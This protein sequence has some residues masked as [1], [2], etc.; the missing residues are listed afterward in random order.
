MAVNN[1]KIGGDKIKKY[2]LEKQE[3]N[4]DCSAAC[5]SMIIQYYKGHIDMETLRDC[6]HIT[7]NGSTAFHL[8]EGARKIGFNANGY[9]CEFADFQKEKIILPCIANVVVN[10]SYSHF[11]VIYE[12]NY[13][14]KELIIADP[15]NKIMKVTFDNF[16]LIYSGVIIILYPEKKLPYTEKTKFSLKN[17]MYLLEGSNKFIINIILLSIFIITYSVIASFYAQFMLRSIENPPNNIKFFFL[18]IIFSLIMIFKIVSEFFR[19]QLFIYITQK[20]ELILGLDTFDKILSLPY[21]YYRNHTTGDIISRIRESSIIRDVISKWLITIII[22]IPLMIISFICIYFISSNLAML[23]LIIFFLYVLLLKIFN[24]SLENAIEHCQEENSNL[25]SNQIESISAFETIKGINIEKFIKFKIEKAQVKFLN[26]LYRFQKITIIETMMKDLIYNIGYFF[27]FLFGC[28]YV[29]NEIISFGSLLTFQSLFGY[30]VNPI[31]Q[32]VDLNTETKN[33]KKA[34]NRLTSIY[35]SDKSKGFVKEEIKGKI[36]FNSLSYSYDN[37]NLILKNINLEISDKEK[38]IIIG[39]SGSGKST[40]FKLLKGYYQVGRNMIYINDIDINDYEK[41]NSILYI[42]QNEIL[43]T[44]S[45]YNN[46]VFDNKIN[47]NEYYEITKLC[48]ID[49]IIKNNNLG[50][51]LLIEEN[52]SNLSGGERQRI[53]LARTLLRNFNILIIDEGLNQLDSDLERR[54]LINLFKK[55]NNKTIIVISHRLEN[56]D[57]FDRMVKFKDGTIIENIV[58]NG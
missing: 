28:L 22:D 37:Y 31:R 19:S 16:N 57:L 53:I 23:S 15:A 56:L 51:S 4:K 36:V 32:L 40:L 41:K 52:G 25:T 35:V 8:I 58:K 20:I 29:Q 49:K 48:E 1:N 21:R 24:N 44:D 46:I 33:A 12:I 10:K 34:F 11:I 38:V 43:F 42:N 3:E 50:Y 45:L 14:K 55:F 18:F 47:Q 2:P 5:I 7:K 54:I 27:I 13:K 6:L 17:I 26:S 9:Q 39:K 30:F